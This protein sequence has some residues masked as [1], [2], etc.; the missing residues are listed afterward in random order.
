[1]ENSLFLQN[2]GVSGTAKAVL[3]FSRDDLVEAARKLNVEPCALSA[4]CVVE[5]CGTGFLPSGRPKILFEGH[6]FWQQLKKRGLS[7]ERLSSN[8]QDILYP[9]WDRSK[10]KG[11]EREYDRL[12]S[13]VAIHEEAA[14]CSTSW[15]AF[16]IMG[17]NYTLCGFTN[18]FDFV[19]AHKMTMR[20]QLK[21]FCYFIEKQN[22]VRYLRCK[23]WTAFARAYN[24]PGYVQNHY[25]LKLQSAYAQCIKTYPPEKI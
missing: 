25:D 16:Q 20:E 5:S 22:M 2:D 23:D 15:G 8:H 7:P 1:M 9:K 3:G 11:G 24:G 18:I 10:Y 19:A 14:L 12:T 13:A 6:V 17:H 4:V 21:T